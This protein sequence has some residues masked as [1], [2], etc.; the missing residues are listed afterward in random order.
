MNRESTA[1]KFVLKVINEFKQFNEK[2]HAQ[3]AM[4]IFI[5]NKKFPTFSYPQLFFFQIVS[6]VGRIRSLRNHEPFWYP[7]TFYENPKDRKSS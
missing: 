2:K 6:P 4:K 7:R 5:E 3:R 1:L